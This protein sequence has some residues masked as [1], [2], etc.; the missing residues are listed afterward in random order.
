MYSFT[1]ATFAMTLVCHDA[2]GPI[3]FDELFGTFKSGAG[4]ALRTG[5]LSLQVPFGQQKQ[6]HLQGLLARA[7]ETQPRSL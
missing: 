3:C 7:V 6:V 1:A 5:S 4:P 2:L